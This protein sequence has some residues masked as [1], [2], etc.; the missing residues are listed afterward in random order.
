MNEKLKREEW[1]T[2]EV[3]KTKFNDQALKKA[4]ELA[5]IPRSHSLA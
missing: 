2:F 3:G 4:G 1:H 5:F